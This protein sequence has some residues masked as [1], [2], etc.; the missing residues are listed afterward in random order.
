MIGC[1]GIHSKIRSYVVPHNTPTASFNGQV[2]LARI[3][4]MALGLALLILMT[5][6]VV[7]G[8][9]AMEV[10]GIRY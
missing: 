9:K 3:L 7:V 2:L 5:I 6:P 4:L 8:R 1:D 10:A